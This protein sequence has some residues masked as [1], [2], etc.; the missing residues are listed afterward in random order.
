MLRMISSV[1]LSFFMGLGLE[2][3]LGWYALL[4]SVPVPVIMYSLLESRHA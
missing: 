3:Y 1:L 4:V 2:E